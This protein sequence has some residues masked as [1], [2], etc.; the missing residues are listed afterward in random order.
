MK[1]KKAWRAECD[2]DWDKREREKERDDP[3]SE[4]VWKRMK[5]ALSVESAGVD[6][7]SGLGAVCNAIRAPYR[8]KP[9]DRAETQPSRPAH[10]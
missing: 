7:S 1:K 5:S 2:L 6:T 4:C 3:E 8:D 9:K 10:A